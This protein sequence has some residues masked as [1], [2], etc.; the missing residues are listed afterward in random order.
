MSQ[1]QEIERLRLALEASEKERKE[2]QEANAIW[3]TEFAMLAKKSRRFE[4][5][6]QL[7]EYKLSLVSN[8]P[9]ERAMSELSDERA[10]ELERAFRQLHSGLHARGFKCFS[11]TTVRMLINQDLN[12]QNAAAIADVLHNCDAALSAAED[13]DAE[14]AAT[15]L[16]RSSVQV[17]RLSAGAVQQRLAEQ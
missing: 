7:A 17:E 14:L 9:Q 13:G 16:L 1:E 6:L 10:A 4:K 5:D 2:W 15:T 3:A 8:P 12:E 11:A